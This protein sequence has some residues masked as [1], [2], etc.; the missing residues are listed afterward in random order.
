VTGDSHRP[1]CRRKHVSYLAERGAHWILTMKGSPAC[2]PG[3][4]DHPEGRGPRRR[5][6][7]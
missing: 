4:R 3:S 2:T 7:R 5:E 1:H 6:L